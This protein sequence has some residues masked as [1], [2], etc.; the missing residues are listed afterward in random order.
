MKVHFHER[1]LVDALAQLGVQLHP[2]LRLQSGPRAPRGQTTPPAM[3]LPGSDRIEISEQARHLAV[4]NGERAIEPTAPEQRSA[5]APRGE[6]RE[7]E[8]REIRELERRDAQVRAHER[9]HLAAAGDLARGGARFEYVRGP[10]G[11]M[12]AVNGEVSIDTQPVSGDPE[13]TLRKARRIQ[14]AA[15]APADPSAQDHAVAREAAAMAR[16]AET[17]IRKQRAQEAYGSAQEADG[18][19]PGASKHVEGVEI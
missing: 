19:T 6:S 8:Q 7:A 16:E 5:I 18:T 10:N 4:Q 9:A 1:Q 14:R 2:E 13:A 11:Q 17:E 15:H 12:Y 3:R